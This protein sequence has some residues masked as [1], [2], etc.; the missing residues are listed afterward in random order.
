M[1]RPA[2][3]AA[4][5]KLAA[6]PEELA[7]PHWPALPPAAPPSPP[8]PASSLPP[9]RPRKPLFAP[10]TSTTGGQNPQVYPLSKRLAVEHLPSARTPGCDH[11]VPGCR[12]PSL[13]DK[14]AS[15]APATSY[16]PVRPPEPPQLPSQAS[17]QSWTRQGS[18][19]R[20]LHSL[21]AWL[22]PSGGPAPPQRLRQSSERHLVP[23]RRQQR[24]GC[25]GMRAQM[26]PVRR[27]V[28]LRRWKRRRFE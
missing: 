20:R 23:P 21:P 3:P 7:A 9:A 5:S 6:L 10:P 27:T 8:P 13:A 12:P 19:R 17:P 25:R 28:T 14:A 22:S 2:R 26:R 11:H 4:R 24:V 16:L 15:A 1:K 18:R